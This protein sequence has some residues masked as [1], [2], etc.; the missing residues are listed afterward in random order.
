MPRTPFRFLASMA[1]LAFVLATAVTVVAQEQSLRPRDW[2]RIQPDD[3]ARWRLL[4]RMFGGFAPAMTAVRDHFA[5]THE[6][7]EDG[8]L[9]LAR[10]HWDRV[11]TYVEHGYLRRPDRQANAN[12]LFLDTARVALDEALAAGDPERSRAAF[13][14]ART[15]CMTCHV[16]EGRPYFNDQRLFRSTASFASP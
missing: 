15:A 6:T 4:E 3:E 16:A 14:D 5:M 7:I 10:W 12:A 8:N 2:L 9:E 11:Q 1:L 13:L